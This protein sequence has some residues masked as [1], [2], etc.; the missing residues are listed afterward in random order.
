MQWTVSGDI[1]L[2]YQ[3]V[4]FFPAGL[5]IAADRFEL[6][7]VDLLGGDP[8]QRA[9]LY[10]SPDGIDWVYENPLDWPLSYYSHTAVDD[11]LWTGTQFIAISEGEIVRKPCEFSAGLEITCEGFRQPMDEPVTVRGKRAV[12]PLHATLWDADD[13]IVSNLSIDSPPVAQ[14]SY[15]SE[16]IPAD[17][18]PLEDLV[19]V[20]DATQ[21]NIFVYKTDAEEW[22]L[23]LNAR[24]YSAVGTYVITM[25]SGDEAEY[26]IDPQCEGRFVRTR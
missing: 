18:I 12:L 11:L 7:G 2:E 24:F 9:V 20:S 15:T 17:D 14:V 16:I 3:G 5:A 26:G 23:N 21:D 4:F 19:P 25:E 8:F 22:H 10:G 6:G 13:F 1:A